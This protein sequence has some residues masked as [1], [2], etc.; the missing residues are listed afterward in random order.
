MR[1]RRRSLRQRSG[2]K[3]GGQP[4]HPGVTR[5]LVDDPATIV[6]H[7]PAV[8]AGCGASLETAPEIKRE[9]RQVIDLPEPRPVVAEHQA[10]FKADRAGAGGVRGGLCGEGVREVPT[11]T[12]VAVMTSVQ[13]VT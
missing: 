8:C 5:C 4:G 6:A 13:R 9:R 11:S 12:A 1:P 2:K 10:A 7:V 3:G